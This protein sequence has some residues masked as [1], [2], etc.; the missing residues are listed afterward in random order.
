MP[1]K[2][3]KE[4]SKVK[5]KD[6]VRVHYTGK[7]EDGQVFDSSVD[8]D[9]IEFTLGQG[10]II[11]GFEKGLMDMAVNEK[12]TIN[13]PMA[14][15]YGPHSAELIQDV[16]KQ[17]LPEEVKPEVGMK[18]MSKLPD[19][20]EIPLTVTEVKD[21]SITVDANHPLAGKDLTFDLELIEIK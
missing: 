9:P 4:M 12:K 17:E 19:G 7:L 11:P 13:I 10:Q 1:K 21:E 18:L 8:K 20:R 5:E 6:T 3:I 16:P 15:A 14:E 2:K